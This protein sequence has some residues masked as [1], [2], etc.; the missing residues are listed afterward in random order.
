MM[1]GIRAALATE[2]RKVTSTRSFLGLAIALVVMLLVLVA[3][4]VNVPPSENIRIN[5]VPGN[6]K[7]PLLFAQAG[8]VSLFALIAGILVSTTEFRYGTIVASLLANPSRAALIAAK[9]VVGAALAL[10]LALF[11]IAVIVAIGLPWLSQVEPVTVPG[12]AWERLGREAAV[13]PLWG[14]LGVGIGVLV[15]SQVVAVVG[16]VAWTLIVEN[17]V[18][19]LRPGLSRWL[20]FGV[21]GSISG[22]GGGDLLVWWAGL[23][24]FLAY[25]AAATTAGAVRLARSD[26]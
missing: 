6:Q 21:D 10:G 23:A 20:L 7:V 12:E 9:T 15:R 13:A 16:A 3:L 5:G 11:A 19:N 22:R 26:V 2:S 18:S 8:T 24:L 14:A 17:L 4:V 1:P 25:V